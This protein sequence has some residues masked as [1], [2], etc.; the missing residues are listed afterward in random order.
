[1]SEE[2]HQNQMISCRT[3]NLFKELC[4]SVATGNREDILKT[5]RLVKLSPAKG[6]YLSSVYYDPIQEKSTKLMTSL[7]RGDFDQVWLTV[8]VFCPIPGF[9][10]TVQECVYDSLSNEEADRIIDLVSSNTL[11]NLADPGSLHERKKRSDWN[12]FSL[13]NSL[14]SGQ[15][16]L[17]LDLITKRNWAQAVDI[18]LI[19]MATHGSPS[20]IKAFLA[21]LEMI[22][23]STIYISSAIEI[24]L[25][26]LDAHVLE[27]V[28]KKLYPQSKPS[29]IKILN[30]A[31]YCIQKD[32]PY[33]TETDD[34]EE[35]TD[36]TPRNIEPLSRVVS[37]IQEYTTQGKR[38]R[39]EDLFYLSIHN[40]AFLNCN[41]E[42]IVTIQYCQ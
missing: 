8:A 20:M 10:P 3:K 16:N 4:S 18:L 37:S 41:K 27:N 38:G 28:L 23:P 14:L 7:L 13:S 26:R 19:N 39:A 34:E 35:Q 25:R 11:L 32:D 1:M 36:M 12:L 5:L 30:M 31:C 33:D 9:W 42:G 21:R 24:V 40:M 15:A 29:M 2:I 22:A 6:L 17:N